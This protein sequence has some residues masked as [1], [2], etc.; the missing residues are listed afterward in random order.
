M[1]KEKKLVVY[2][3]NQKAGLIIQNLSLDIDYVID[4][5]RE[6]WGTTFHNKNI[7]GPNH[8]KTVDLLEVKVILSFTPA[9]HV[10]K[11]ISN[12]LKE[13]GLVEGIHFFSLY[14]VLP[15]ECPYEVIMPYSDY[16]PWREDKEFLNTFEAVSNNTL[17]DIYRA[18]GLWS[19]VE[20]VRNVEGAFLEVGVWRGGTGALIA[21][22]VQL[23][24]IPSNIYLCD[25][26]EGVVKAHSAYD[27]AYT[28]GEHKD[29]S[30]EIVR[31]LIERKMQLNNVKILKG[32]FPEDTHKHILDEKISFC[33]IDV[34]VYLSA[35]EVFE[36]VWRRMDVGGIVVF[37]DYGFMACQGITQLVNELKLRDDLVFI[38]SIV[39]G[40]VIKIK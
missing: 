4:N 19:L 22:K 9:G 7:Y 39:H 27:N 1:E 23:C 33:H 31:N 5:D 26:F 11:T 38:Y 32:I 37:D 2:G 28:G 36:W 18:Y 16:A 21:R 29:T 15:R 34:D 14:D 3:T 8:L 40:V 12:S 6:K 20:Q 13:M 24:A 17:V 25:T 30:E 35:K 10:Y